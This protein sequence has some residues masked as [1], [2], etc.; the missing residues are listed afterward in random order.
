MMIV[1]FALFLS[2]CEF[3]FFGVFIN[4]ENMKLTNQPKL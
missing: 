4:N 3:V 2:L 1:S